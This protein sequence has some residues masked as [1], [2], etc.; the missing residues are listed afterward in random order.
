MMGRREKGV[1]RKSDK[2][3][4]KSVP[5]CVGWWIVPMSGREAKVREIEMLHQRFAGPI[6]DLCVRLLGDRSEAEDAVQETFINAYRFWDTFRY[7]E[8][9]L[10]W[11]YRIANNVCLKVLRARKGSLTA[12][13]QTAASVKAPTP[14]PVNAIHAG[15]VIG[16]LVHELDDRSLEILIAVYVI[17]MNQRQIAQTMGISRRSVV[18]RLTALRLRTRNLFEEG[19]TVE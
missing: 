5:H 6:Y 13:P 4:N 1:E 17:G 14:N 8:S 3:A 10:P 7:G 15:R 11:L 16:Q 19:E 18:K 2:K 12:D 9:R